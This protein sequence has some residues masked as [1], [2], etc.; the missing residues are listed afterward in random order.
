MIIKKAFLFIFMALLICGLTLLKAAS[1]DQPAVKS[2]IADIAVNLVDSNT[3]IEIKSTSSFTY[4]INKTDPYQIVV[5]LQ[6]TSLGNYTDKIV[7]DRAGI[8]EIKPVKDGNQPNVARFEI[9]LTVPA[10]IEPVYNDNSLILSFDNPDFKN[11][12]TAEVVALET[13]GEEGIPDTEEIPEEPGNQKYAGEK[14]SIDFQDV[15]LLH[16]FRLIADISGFNIVVSPDVKGKF[17][18]KLIDVPWDQ[19]L[20]IILRNYGLSK[21]EENNIIRIAPTSVLAKEEEEIARAKES[22]EKAGD[23]MT[24]VYPINYASVKNIKKAIDDAKILTV[25][26]FISFDERTSSVIIKDVEKKHVEYE[27]LI[28]ALD[29]PTP[30]VSIEA[31]IVE[32]RSELTKE[33][34]IQWGMFWEPPDSRMKFGGVDT[35]SGLA[36]GFNSGSPLMINLPA[37]VGQGKG[38]HMGMGY[39]NSSQLF[40]L[41]IQ[42]S[43]LESTGKA[44]VISN[45]KITT[46][47]NEEARI[48]QGEKIP[49][50]TVSADGTQ[51]EFMDAVLE[52]IVT[53]HITPDGT[54]VMKLQ[55]KKNEADFTKQVLGVPTIAIKEIQTQVLINNHDTL[56]IGGIFTTENTKNLEAVPGFAEIPFI[57]RL[58]QKK[59]D[60]EDKNELLIFITP[61]IVTPTN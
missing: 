18:M 34:G 27:L 49:Y 45:P 59:I 53:P 31:K 35:L 52:L 3:E 23:L 56:V 61:R 37:I 19:A 16:V 58:F 40:K 44:R 15:E 5:D 1:E 11:A 10:D 8:L 42:L 6:D 51:T 46:S 30:Q 12:K 7:I 55:A 39:I 57:G 36:N 33:L 50:Q 43:A 22:R 13:E 20:D 48:L 28:D 4:T 32:V 9:S 25:R 26:G 17:T 38:G 24:K 21:I 54:V 2:E 14:I 41:D 47:D 60:I 29:V